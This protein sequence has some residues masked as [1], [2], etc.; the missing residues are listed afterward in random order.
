MARL[1]PL[2]AAVTCWGKSRFC[3]MLC[4]TIKGL[5][6][7]SLSGVIPPCL[8]GR[9]VPLISASPRTAPA[10]FSEGPSGSLMCCLFCPGYAPS[11]KPSLT[12]LNSI[13]PLVLILDITPFYI[14][15]GSSLT[16]DWNKCISHV[17][18]LRT[19]LRSTVVWAV[20]SPSPLDNQLESRELF[21]T[22]AQDREAQ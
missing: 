14:D 7:I 10:I 20:I 2:T 21:V 16:Q 13:H 18:P 4:K 9:T 15:E 11:S 5:V 8:Q 12:S 1:K 22:G 3:C 17:H 19:K 6:S